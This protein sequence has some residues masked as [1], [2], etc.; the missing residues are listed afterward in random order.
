MEGHALADSVGCWGI[1][2]G[3]AGMVSQVEGLAQAVGLP[4]QLKHCQLR[5]TL[6]KLWPGLIPSW[7]STLRNGREFTEHLPRLAISCGRQSVVAARILKRVG[8]KQVVTVHTQ[9]P[10]ISQSEFDLLVVPE[11]DGLQGDN[12]LATRGAVHRLSPAL[13]REAR[14]Q[15]PDAAWNWN[16]LQDRIV[17]V[18][19]G[20]PNRHHEFTL[21]SVAPF[22]EML[23]SLSI[24]EPVSMAILP[25][26][27]TPKAVVDVL[28]H[29]LGRSHF[30]WDGNS[31][32]PYLYALSTAE[33][34]VVTGD[35][36]SM[37]S[38][39]LTTGRPV[40]VFHLPERRVAR[41]FRRFHTAFEE[42][43]YTRRF[44]GHL[45]E[46]TYTPPDETARVAELIR[47]RL[48]RLDVP[49]L[50]SRAA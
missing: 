23:R 32:N 4:F 15:G 14:R 31:P 6:R 47:Q 39:A 28:R 38:E 49:D 5:P 22:I 36:V 45:A 19:V 40:H 3:A 35:S 2:D 13:L 1:S 11:H 8:G 27:R 29:A 21:K 25:S 7:P 26:R 46:W 44:A 30:I 37:T 48:E 41:R 10:R 43:G 17:C 24:R 34:V 12:V 50:R 33:H 9:D 42:Y 20:G 18:L 16:R